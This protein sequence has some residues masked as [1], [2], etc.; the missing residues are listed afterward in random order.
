MKRLIAPIAAPLFA[1]ATLG[2]IGACGGAADPEPT[3]PTA[4]DQSISPDQ[5]EPA[6]DDGPDA[7]AQAESGAAVYESSCGFCHGDAGEGAGNNPPVVGDGVLASY[8][9]AG[10]LLQYVRSEMPVDEPGGLSDEEFQDVVAFM[11]QAN[12]I[13]LTGKSITPEAATSITF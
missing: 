5:A 12:G 6:V 13:D 7:I 1:V 10:E 3:T 4:P 8:A 2:L 9:D 11:L